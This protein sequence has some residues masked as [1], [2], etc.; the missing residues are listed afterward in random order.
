MSS[1]S[2]FPEVPDLL[3]RFAVAPY[4]ADYVIGQTPV[5]IETNH[6]EILRAFQPFL[7]QHQPI[8]GPPY[9][10]K[11]IVD[12]ELST[13]SKTTPLEI[14]DGSITVGNNC[15]MFFALDRDSQE[16]M[17]FMPRFIAANFSELVFR[18]LARK[19]PLRAAS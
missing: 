5:H 6:P 19:T 4:E 3:R 15:D 12:P 17:L 2:N 10:I 1:W 13:R 18:L 11:A 8:S 14:D 9:S 7:R 16:L